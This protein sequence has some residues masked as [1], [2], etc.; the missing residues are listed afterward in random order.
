[1]AQH[2]QLG[3]LGQVRTNQH[4]QQAEQATQQPVDE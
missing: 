4:R 3:L 1:M 2:Q